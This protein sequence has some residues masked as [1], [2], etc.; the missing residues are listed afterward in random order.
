MIVF[1]YVK[2][3]KKY[4]NVS[5]REETLLEKLKIFY[6]KPDNFDTF[7][8]I[9]LK[10]GEESTISL[11]IIDHFVTNY[12]KQSDVSYILEKNN[13]IEHFMVYKSYKSELKGYSKKDFDPFRRTILKKDVVRDKITV[14]YDQGTKKLETT[15]AQL[16]FF[17]WAI[18]NKII[19]YIY[20]HKD[21]I[22]KEMNHY[23]KRTHD[24]KKECVEKELND[25][26][27]IATKKITKNDVT[28][29]IKFEN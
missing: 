20:E 23:H 11:R 29:T 28:I 9:I 18:E 14:Y 6:E 15:I 5:T 21:E 22:E 2:K 7:R 27:M 13:K 8:K 1:D 16:N 19:Q 25:M 4:K 3:E 10:E 12:C 17:K 26:K 24:K